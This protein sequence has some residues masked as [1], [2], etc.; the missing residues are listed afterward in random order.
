MKVTKRKRKKK[1]KKG[2]I[3]RKTVNVGSWKEDTA[4]KVLMNVSIFTQSV[5]LTRKGI[6]DLG[7]SAFMYTHQRAEKLTPE[8]LSPANLKGMGGALK[9]IDSNIDMNEGRVGDKKLLPTPT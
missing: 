1:L 5:K 9:E 8:A 4:V 3:R 6:A 2:T 7:R